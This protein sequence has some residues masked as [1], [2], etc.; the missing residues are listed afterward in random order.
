MIELLCQEG[1]IVFSA[2]RVVDLILLF[3]LC[4]VFLLVR[5]VCTGLYVV[6]VGKDRFWVC[7]M[8]V[9]D[10]RVVVVVLLSL[11]VLF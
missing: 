4:V 7:P 2:I 1:D 3:D 5:E 10:E 9:A 6:A 8:P 11:F